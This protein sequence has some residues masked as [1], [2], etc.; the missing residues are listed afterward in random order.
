MGIFFAVLAAILV[1]FP[2]FL[3]WCNRRVATDFEAWLT[4]HGWAL[5]PQCP[6]PTP[7]GFSDQAIGSLACFNGELRPGMP[8]T[9]IFGVRST[10]QP[11]IDPQPIATSYLGMYFPPAVKLD[12]SWLGQ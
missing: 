5:R 9:L 7:F 11:G 6:V 1:G 3:W 2:L 10:W 4:G 8:M 12:D